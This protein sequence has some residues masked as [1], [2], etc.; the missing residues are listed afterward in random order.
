[1]PTFQP[2]TSKLDVLALEQ[3]QRDYW[4]AQDVFKRTLSEREGGPKFVF[5]EGPPTANGRPGSHHVLA[6]SFK[7]IFPRYKVMNGYRVIRKAGWDTHGLPVEIEVEKELGI[8]NK[9]EIEQYG[10]AEFNRK[11]RESVFRYMQEW[12]KFTE[13]IAFWVDLDDAYVTYRNEYIES[14]WWILKQFFDRGL[15]YQGYKSVPYCARCGTPLSSHELAQ[16]YLDVDDVSVYVRFALRDEPDTAFL[17][18]TTTPWTLPGN[19]ALAV[20]KNETY[21]KVEGPIGEGRE[22]LILA[23]ALMSKLRHPEAYT[24]IERMKGEALLGVHYKPMFKF[25]LVEQDYCYV[26]HGD[27]VSMDDGTGIVHIAPAFGTDDLELGKQYGLPMLQTVKPDGTFIEA[28]TPWAG[29]WFKVADKEIIKYVRDHGILFHAENYHHSYPHCWR[30][31]TPLMYYARSTWYIR[32]TDFR[33]RMVALNETIHWEPEHIKEGRFGNWL[34]ENRDWALGR[35]RFWGTPLTIW[36]CDNPDSSEALCVGSVAELSA[37]AGRDLSELDLHRPYVDEITWPSKDGLGTMRRVPEL[38]DVWFDSGAMPYAQW[39]YPHKNR[40]LFEQQYPAD[41]I[42][43]AIDQTRGWFYSLHAISTLLNDSVAFRNVIC[44]GH[45]LDDKGRKMSKSLGNIVKPWDVLDKYGAD[46]FRWYLFTAAAPGDSRR[47]SVELVGE[48]IRNFTL[49]LW[50]T[51]SFFVTYANIDAFDPLQAQVPLTERDELDRWILSELHR[52]VARVTAGY[53]AYDVTEATR[54][55]QAFVDDLSNWYLRRSRRRF[56]KAETDS[57]KVAAYQTLYECLITLAKLLAPAMPYVAEA[58]YRNLNVDPSAPNSVH[59]ATWPQVDS[60]VVDEK[61]VA[62][63]GLVKKLAELGRSAREGV[64][65]KLRQPLAEG[66][67]GVRSLSERNAL[68][69]LKDVL[70]EELN[71]KQVRLLDAGGGV[72]SYT[73]NPLPQKLGRKFGGDFPR[74]QKALREADP[75]QVTAWAK[76]LLDGE[77][78]HFEY[79]GADGALKPGTVTPDECEVRQSASAGYAVAEELGLLAALKTDLSD[80]LLAEGLTREAVRRV[81]LMRREADFALDDRI[82]ITYTAT[83]KLSRALEQFR[84]YLTTETLA[85]SLSNGELADAQTFEFDGETLTLALHKLEASA[86]QSQ[87]VL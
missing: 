42:C 34:A 86:A 78:I 66:M 27:F 29:K 39:G 3:E 32:T 68:E 35:E 63:M 61:L 12:E 24:V 38:I 85:E 70:A 51:Y 9:A 47:F 10:I 13:R 84:D 17:A 33:E 49:T 67:F 59:L 74:V 18:W 82:A 55:I 7:D 72:V 87:S 11:C 21:V 44:L 15:I 75:V 52:L 2:V 64:N 83:P 80:D 46:A 69:R 8:K 30:C 40:E 71:I 43:E 20:N 14:E 26:V 36:K 37:L 56:W 41:Y 22:R 81:Q 76:A 79:A 54:P 53:E 62:E 5:Y 31:K 23:E 1:M 73:L 19:V 25:M 60:A 16:G 65:I 57:D 50:N 28:V 4:K 77:P 45:I 6:R 58:L 48:V